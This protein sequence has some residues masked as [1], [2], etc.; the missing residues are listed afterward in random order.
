VVA[1]L[2]AQYELGGSVRTVS[3]TLQTSVRT[4]F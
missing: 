2:V 4:L 1:I 3:Y